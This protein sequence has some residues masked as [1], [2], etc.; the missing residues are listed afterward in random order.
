MLTCR[1][2]HL[3]L[4]K[5]STQIQT[6]LSPL[7]VIRVIERHGDDQYSHNLVVKVTKVHYDD[8]D[9]IKVGDVE[10]IKVC[11]LPFRIKFKRTYRLTGS[12]EL[13]SNELEIS[14]NGILANIPERADG[15]LG[16]GPCPPHIRAGNCDDDPR[17]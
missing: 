16:E 14:E 9:H 6:C 7:A 15:P 5:V 2:M 11:S 4:Q 1:L 17:S 8:I 10:I 13:G 12:R 3:S